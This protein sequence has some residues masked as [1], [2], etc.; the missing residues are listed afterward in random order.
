MAEFDFSSNVVEAVDSEIGE[1]LALRRDNIPNYELYGP[2]DLCYL[3][4]ER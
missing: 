1:Q 3:I 2:P 4:K